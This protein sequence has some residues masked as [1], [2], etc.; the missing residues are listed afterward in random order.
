MGSIDPTPMAEPAF[1]RYEFTALAEAMPQLV[2]IC[3]A[4]GRIVYFNR[5]WID[6]TG[7]DVAELSDAAPNNIVHPDDLDRTWSAWNAALAERTPY[8]IEYRL[9]RAHDHSYRWFIARAVPLFDHAGRV[10]SWVG[11][12]TDIDA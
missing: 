11:T 12:A 5:P 4:H 6:Y 8:E 9:R 7:V 3:D 2:W 10:E 1:V